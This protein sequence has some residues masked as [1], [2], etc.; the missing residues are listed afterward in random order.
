[1]QNALQNAWCLLASGSSVGRR[2]ATVGD[3]FWV[4]GRG[5]PLLLEIVVSPLK[6]N[7]QGYC[8]VYI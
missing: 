3:P 6:L 1:L 2:K 5:S 8:S 7:K 4:L